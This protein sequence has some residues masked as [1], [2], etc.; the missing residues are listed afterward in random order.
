MPVG[1]EDRREVGA[2]TVFVMPVGPACRQE[3]VADTVESIRHFAPMARIILVDDSQRK[4]GSELAKQYELVVLVARVHGVFGNLYLNLSDGF[5]EALVQP[6]RVLVRL[7]TDALITGSGFEAR[8][9]ELF[10]ADP[11]LGSLG[12][13][14]IAFDG[15]IR[16]AGWAKRRILTYLTVRGWAR[17]RAM[18]V[19]IGLLQ[20]A[21]RHD[22]VLG[23][24]VQGG[25]A[26]Y[27]YEAVKELNESDLLGRAELARIGLQ[28]D[29]IFGLCLYS[30]GYHL[31]EFGSRFDDLPM[32]VDWRVLPAAPQELI[33]L[34]K[35]IVHSTKSFNDMDEASIRREFRVERDRPPNG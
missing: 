18:L 29:Y 17:P 19:V 13:H 15:G 10:D 3:F 11:Q 23:D 2:D 26:L 16:S 8:A 9:I 21:R 30:I 4:L 28:E 25:A 6:F 12:S 14:R 20:R 31:G 32:G 27:R 22:Y 24:S 5:R 7:D 1:S 33:E 34:G 35:S